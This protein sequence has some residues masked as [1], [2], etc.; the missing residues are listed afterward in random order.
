MSRMTNPDDAMMEEQQEADLGHLLDESK[1]PDAG[2][3]RLPEGVDADGLIRGAQEM[4]ESA[5][6]EK[7]RHAA[8]GRAASA[9]RRRH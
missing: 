4:D 1:A 9:S 3:R 8:A 6:T 7:A 2:I 5:D